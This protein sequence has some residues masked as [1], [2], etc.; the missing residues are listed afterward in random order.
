MDSSGEKKGKEGLSQEP[1]KPSQ[2]EEKDVDDGMQI[3]DLLEKI[4]HLYGTIL[5]RL[6]ENY[7]STEESLESLSNSYQSLLKWEM[8]AMPPSGR[9]HSPPNLQSLVT[10]LSDIA[11][12]LYRGSLLG[13]PLCSISQSCAYHNLFQ[14]S[15]ITRRSPKY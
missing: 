8:M 10:A 1:Q 2:S 13:P 15:F 11:R 7:G 9:L 14:S 6:Q 5:L 3:T 12:V 4:R